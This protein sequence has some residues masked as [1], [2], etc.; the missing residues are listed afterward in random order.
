MHRADYCLKHFKLVFFTPVRLGAKNKSYEYLSFRCLFSSSAKGS[1]RCSQMEVVWDFGL[2]PFFFFVK[3]VNPSSSSESGE[4]TPRESSPDTL[5]T[6]PPVR[7]NN[8]ALTNIRH[9]VTT[10]TKKNHPGHPYYAI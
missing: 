8:L 1:F 4:G 2:T 3:T 9:L 7:D 10:L 6:L 5:I